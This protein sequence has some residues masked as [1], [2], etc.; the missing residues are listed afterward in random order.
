MSRFDK[1][2]F[3]W[4]T[5]FLIIIVSGM[6]TAEQWETTGGCVYSNV[7]SYFPMHWVACEL[8]RKRW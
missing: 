8:F 5:F 1:L 4:L 7:V 6:E 2:M 3:F